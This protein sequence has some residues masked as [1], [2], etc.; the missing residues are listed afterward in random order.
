MWLPAAFECWRAL[1]VRLG[2]LRRRPLLIGV[3]LP[4][5][6]RWDFPAAST[7]SMAAERSDITLSSTG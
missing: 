7:A 5:M 6:C 1:E 3:C 4:V 2:Q